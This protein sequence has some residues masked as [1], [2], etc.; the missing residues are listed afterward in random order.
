[1]QTYDLVTDFGCAC[2]GLTDDF[3]ALSAGLAEVVPG[4]EIL[5]PGLCAL[6]GQVTLPPSVRVVGCGCAYLVGGTLYSCGGPGFVLHPSAGTTQI[7]TNGQPGYSETGNWNSY[8]YGF[9]GYHRA[10]STVTGSPTTTATWA[11]SNL[12]AGTYGVYLTW[13]PAGDRPTALGY[14]IYDG[15]TSLGTVTVNQTLSPVGPAI[16]EQWQFVGSF[17]V[18]SGTLK[19]V[20]TNQT[21]NGQHITSNAA[22]ITSNPNGPT[23]SLLAATNTF[24]T[25]IENLILDA[26]GKAPFC[27]IGDRWSRGALKDSV[28]VNAN[29]YCLLWGASQADQYGLPSYNNRIDRVVL[30]GAGG[31]QF[32]GFGCLG[33]AQLMTCTQLYTDFTRHHGVNLWQGDSNTFTHLDTVHHPTAQGYSLAWGSND[34]GG[35]ADGTQSGAYCQD[36]YHFQPGSLQQSPINAIY[37]GG[38]V[39][40]ANNGGQYAGRIYSWDRTNVPSVSAVEGPSGAIAGVQLK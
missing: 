24:G 10:A 18:Q 39:P 27:L 16:G 7:I 4:S 34:Y 13:I 21:A 29:Q 28:L 5:V 37:I 14:S 20:L 12:A 40:S 9:G 8:L 31:L 32:R 25:R 15:S 19:V 36:I 17:P 23:G 6:S 1:M 33:G 2:D 3:S 22:L 26:Q 30:N 11:F 35:I 38:L